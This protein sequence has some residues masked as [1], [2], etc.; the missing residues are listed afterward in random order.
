MTTRIKGSILD[1]KE[2]MRSA[3]HHAL[4]TLEYCLIPYYIV[5]FEGWTVEI[6]TQQTTSDS[7]QCHL[8][9]SISLL[10]VV[11]L[12]EVTFTVTRLHIHHLHLSRLQ[13]PS[14]I[15]LGR[16]VL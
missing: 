1:G 10:H 13:S 14:H 2:T 6:L 16:L 7:N 5:A 8:S 15:A 9:C 11:C 3:R 4:R 12:L